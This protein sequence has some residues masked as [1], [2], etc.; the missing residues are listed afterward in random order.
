MQPPPEI[1]FTPGPA[2]TP[3]AG[4][5]SH[6][7]RLG[8]EAPARRVRLPVVLTLDRERLAILEARLGR[9][10][11]ASRLRLDDGR[12]GISLLDRA[13]DLCPPEGRCVLRLV[14]YWRGS[15]DGVGQLDVLRVDGPAQ[16]A[17]GEIVE[18][19]GTPDAA[20][21]VAAASGQNLPKS[22]ARGTRR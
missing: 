21:P 2:L 11:D 22:S 8:A 10:D 4:A 12:L 19:E 5:L 13:R 3:A 16:P 9:G 20:G 7:D 6:L 1:A 18:V 15:S 17:A 14:G